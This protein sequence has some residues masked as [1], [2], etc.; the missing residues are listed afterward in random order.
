M[1]LATLLRLVRDGIIVLALV[2]LLVLSAGAFAYPWID[3]PS[4][5]WTPIERYSPIHDGGS[6]LTIE[7][8]ANNTPTRWSST[9]TAILL[10]ARAL[11]SDLRDGSR[12]EILQV[13]RQQGGQGK[14]DEDTLATLAGTRIIETRRRDLDAS[15]HPTEL[16]FD[17]MRDARGE[18][19][20]SLFSPANNTELVYDPPALLFP[21]N[22]THR[23]QCRR[24]CAQRF[25]RLSGV[26]GKPAVPASPWRRHGRAA[27]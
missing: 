6:S 23:L 13:A 7:Y 14:T 2:F 26:W 8:D 12:K 9:N 3:L 4:T 19:L 24:G 17:S 25:P 22:I 21:A 20:V 27:P 5:F 11:A 15:G 16:I 18:Y 10:N 1:K